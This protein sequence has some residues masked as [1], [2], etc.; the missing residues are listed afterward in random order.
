M[1]VSHL[2]LSPSHFETKSADE[3]EKKVEL[4]ASVATAFAKNDFPV[5]G[6]Y[7]IKYDE[8]IYIGKQETANCNFTW[9]QCCAIKYLQLYV[10]AVCYSL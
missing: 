8:T 9:K 1:H 6:G 2:S 3:T 10:T 7:K 5:P 4:F